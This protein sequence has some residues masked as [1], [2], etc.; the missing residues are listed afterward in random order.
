MNWRSIA[1]IRPGGLTALQLHLGDGCVFGL[2]PMNAGRIYGFAYVLQPRFHDSL[3]ERLERLRNRFAKFGGRLHE[4]LASLERDDQIICSAMEWMDVLLD[5]LAAG[6]G[7]MC[8]AAAGALA[9]QPP[10]PLIDGDAVAAPE[11]V[12]AG[13]LVSRRQRSHAPQNDDRLLARHCRGAC[14]VSAVF[15]RD[16]KPAVTQALLRKP[17]P[18]R[19]VCAQQSRPFS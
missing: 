11:I 19:V 15:D 2:V 7:R 8:S 14:V 5:A 18:S 17:D 4:Y 9:P 12:G 16:P 13:K 1:P 10:A 3:E 6:V